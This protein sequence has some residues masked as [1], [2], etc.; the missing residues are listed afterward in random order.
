MPHPAHGP[1]EGGAATIP[2]RGD[3]PSRS[4]LH[5]L[6]AGALSLATVLVYAAITAIL[7]AWIVTR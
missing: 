1:K 5:A 6:A 3:E 2:T 4:S 7:T